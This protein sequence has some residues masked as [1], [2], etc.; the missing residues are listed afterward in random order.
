MLIAPFSFMEASQSLKS[1]RMYDLYSRWAN[2]FTFANT[3]IPSTQKLPKAQS[4][5]FFFDTLAPG[6]L[7]SLP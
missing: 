5:K 3:T 6:L 2:V 1:I 4:I 7:Y